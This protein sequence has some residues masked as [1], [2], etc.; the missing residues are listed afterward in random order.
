MSN[1]ISPDDLGFFIKYLGNDIEIVYFEH[2]RPFCS[3][4]E[5]PFSLNGTKDVKPNKMENIRF[6]QYQCPICKEGVITSLN[7]HKKQFTNYTYMI[8]EK[9]L[10]YELIEYMSFEK[11]AE[12]IE[13][14]IGIVLNRQTVCYHQY[15]YCEEFIEKEQLLIN[16]LIECL[17]IEPS[18]IYCYD[19][20]FV[21]KKI[22]SQVRLT[23]IDA[24]TN[25]I[26]NDQLIDKEEFTPDFI[27]IFLKYSLKDLPKKTLITDGHPAYP[28]IIEKM[29]IDHQLCIFHI[30]KNQ[31]QPIFK[32]NEP[33][34]TKRKKT[35]KQNKRKRRRNRKTQ[36]ILQ[37]KTRK[38]K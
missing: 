25:Q 29:C 20:E 11:K 17:G 3:E 38:K 30:I 27:E 15:R 31:R 35:G 19:E 2:E 10:E 4:C 18:G 26:I 6:Q 21:E 9:A 7:K 36:K 33:Q 22:D 16:Q 5:V 34:H 1:E 12:L 37:R 23:I 24:I 13:E 28:S 8:C 32:K 14:E